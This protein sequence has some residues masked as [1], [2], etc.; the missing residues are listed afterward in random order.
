[1]AGSGNSVPNEGSE[2][3]AKKCVFVEKTMS[4]KYTLSLGV[5][6]TDMWDKEILIG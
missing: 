4:F 6:V 5:N 1:M 3:N 2:E